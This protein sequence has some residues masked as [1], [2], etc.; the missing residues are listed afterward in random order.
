MTPHRHVIPRRPR[1]AAWIAG[2]LAACGASGGLWAGIAYTYGADTPMP[3]QEAAS[4]PV[5]ALTVPPPTV[6]VV[7]VSDTAPLPPAPRLLPPAAEVPAPVTAADLIAITH[8]PVAPVVSTP[9]A[10]LADPPPPEPAR[11]HT[12]PRVEGDRDTHRRHYRASPTPAPRPSS[13]SPT[14][15]ATATPEPTSQPDRGRHDGH[16]G[17]SSDNRWHTHRVEWGAR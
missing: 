8:G 9:A 7:D 13:P 16:H 6:P 3:M 1:P 17:P 4:L 10:V 14:P 11:Q 12:E 15:D 2:S 5:T